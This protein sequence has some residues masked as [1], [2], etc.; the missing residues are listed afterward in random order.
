ME[1]GPVV[2]VVQIN[3]PETAQVSSVVR[4]NLRPR[5]ICMYITGHRVIMGGNVSS[6]S[7][8]FHP[9]FELKIAWLV[10]VYIAERRISV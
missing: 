6:D 8:L 3:H 2:C 10:I 1:N 4:Q 5:F 9:S 7:I